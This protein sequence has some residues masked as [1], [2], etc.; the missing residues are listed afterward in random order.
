MYPR[1][2]DRLTL[3]QF[4][5]YF[6]QRELTQAEAERMAWAQKKKRRKQGGGENVGGTS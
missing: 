2:I 4:R 3:G 5:L 6:K 1:D